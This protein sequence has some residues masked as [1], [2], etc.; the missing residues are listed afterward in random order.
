VG[1][2]SGTVTFLFTD[3]EGSTRLWESA[4]SL[5]A[6][7]L[8]RHE[9]LLRSAVEAHRGYVF[10]TSGD[11]FAA[12]FSRAGDALAAAT[13]TQAALTAEAW[14]EGAV[15]R[16]RM[17]LHT[18]EAQERDGDYFGTPVNQTARLMALA[19]GGQL[20][21]SAVT[22]QIAGDDLSL[23]DL[24]EHRL[25][26]LSAPQR[27]F[28]VGE[29]RFPPLSSADAVPT[30]LPTQR[31]DLIGR[32]QLIAALT[33]LVPDH[34]LITLTGVGGVG[35]TR[36]ALG[37]A[38]VAST[39]YPDG[40]WLVELAPISDGAEVPKAV[41][42]VL[43]A[44]LPD[45]AKLVGYL[46]DRRTLLILDNCE[47]LL[48]AA[49]SFVDAVLQAAPEVHVL[50]TS[51][52]PLGVEGEMIRLVPS[53]ELPPAGCPIDTAMAAASVRLFVERGIAA[54][55]SFTLD[56]GNTDAVVDICRHL[57]GLPLAIELAAAQVRSMPPAE[58]ARRLSERFRLLGGGTRRVHERHRTLQA[59]V[60]WSHDLLD[61]A[62]RRV[63]RRLAVF[64]ASFD[65]DGAEA[66]AGPA[67]IGV[68][69]CV[70]LLVDRC[71]VQFDL[72]AG[73]Y[74]LLETLRQYGADRLAEAGET[75]DTAERHARYFLQLAAKQA[76]QLMGPASPEA[77]HALTAELDNLRA[78]AE[79]CAE[80]RRW[81][82]L[83]AL[84]RQ[85]WPFAVLYSADD[86]ISWHQRI[87]THH[88]DL[89]A[90]ERVNTFGEL[91]YLTVQG[92]GDRAEGRNLADEADRVSTAEQCPASPWS[93]VANALAHNY[94]GDH[95]D[96]LGCCERA[97]VAAEPGHDAL[98]S[99]V[100]LGTMANALAGLG[101]VDEVEGV[102]LDALK[103]S[104][105]VGNPDAIAIGAICLASARL[106]TRSIDFP[107]ALAVLTRYAN[108]FDGSDFSV[109][110]SRLL[111]GYCLLG[112]RDHS[113][114]EP[115][116][117]GARLADRLNAPHALDAA[118]RSLALHCAR[119]GHSDDAARLAG[120]AQARLAPYR[121]VNFLGH[122]IDGHLSQELS[123]NDQSG[124]LG[125]QGA[126][127]QRRD[128][129]N[130]VTDLENQLH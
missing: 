109:M 31:S 51:R 97:L 52:E 115:L 60:S 15:I 122:W 125:A 5:M 32:P 29:G 72:Q 8:E 37:V 103:R 79:W 111:Q 3:V 25:R 108:N 94:A 1:A 45:T 91:A 75:D 10:S 95:K 124:A 114:Y 13:D 112:L 58:I 116:C 99:I 104:E 46:R 130:L 118:L 66:V 35:K 127:W 65:L 14:P 27:I 28:Q 30:N 59:A 64:P 67:D 86:N 42:A 77:K 89:S 119:H 40:C 90:Q 61:E 63:F 93:A 56:G 123:A 100:A 26:D 20:L 2:P 49:A 71:L 34:R 50:A 80:Q 101:D 68:V 23:V 113:A 87:L 102:A 48:S 105:E 33:K 70:M 62:E 9:V 69:E 18:G 47:H 82:E 44:P 129:M 121:I 92:I 126:R 41:A 36:L 83:L 55:A 54:Q 106:N 4:P 98:A 78:A 38:G 21:C 17:G 107:S 74:Q 24:G 96:S 128:V 117:E 110:W 12:A 16:V 84:A 85:T 120:Y 39:G 73:R 6:A 7:A 19:H 43:G 53:L 81:D 76:G 88:P 22:A 57:D 11:G